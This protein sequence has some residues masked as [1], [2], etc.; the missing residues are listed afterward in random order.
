MLFDVIPQALARDL[1]AQLTRHYQR[2]DVVRRVV[3]QCGVKI[4]NAPDDYTPHRADRCVAAWFTRGETS[5]Q[6]AL[7]AEHEQDY[8]LDSE[9]RQPF[10]HRV[11]AAQ[12]VGVVVEE[13]HPHHIGTVSFGFQ[14]SLNAPMG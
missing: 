8:L 3:G 9:L 6:C 1:V 11:A 5:F 2:D 12:S 4:G 10:S 13:H 14:L 7:V